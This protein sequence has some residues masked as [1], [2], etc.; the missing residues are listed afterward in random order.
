MH[1]SFPLGGRLLGGAGGLLLGGSELFGGVGG[2]LLGAS[3]V[4]GGCE[5]FGGY[6]DLGGAGF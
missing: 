2:A 4:F 5:L 1:G 3:G 6:S